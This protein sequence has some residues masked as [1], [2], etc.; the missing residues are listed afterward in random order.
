MP[1]QLKSAIQSGA[2][3]A[4]IKIIRNRIDSLGVSEPTVNRFCTGLG[5]KGFPDFKLT[6]AAEL[7]RSQPAMSQDVEP[8][9]SAGQ[10]ISKLF[11]A[12]RNNL[13]QVEEALDIDAIEQTVGSLRQARSIVLC[14][15]G[16]SASVALDAQHK[17]LRFQ[18]PVA[19]HTDIINQRVVAAG[20]KPEDCMI[21]IS[22]TGRTNAIVEVADPE[23]ET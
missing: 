6:L 20:L 13:S 9:D 1:P 18:L 3:D 4:A 11:T 23:T 17:L 7:A 14:G 8:G 22:Y 19:A 2:I 15:L 16:A 5:L 10:V 12:T 21:C